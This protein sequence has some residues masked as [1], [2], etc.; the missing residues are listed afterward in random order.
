MESNRWRL[1]S[2][3]PANFECA[4][5]IIGSV[6]LLV[7]SYNCERRSPSGSIL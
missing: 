7:E 3:A 1:K 2:A 4:E 6:E 5:L